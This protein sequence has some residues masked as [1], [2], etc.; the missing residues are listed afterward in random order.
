MNGYIDIDM[1]VQCSICIT[2]LAINIDINIHQ[3][4]D[5]T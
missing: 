4:V 1:N 3:F 2:I 5:L